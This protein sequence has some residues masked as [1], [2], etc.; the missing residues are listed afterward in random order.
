MKLALNLL[1]VLVMLVGVNG[2]RP[3]VE[4]PATTNIEVAYATGFSIE[5]LE[6]GVKKLVDGENQTILLIPAGQTAPAG[7]N[8]AVKIEIPVSR[9]VILS[10]TFGALMRPLGVLDSLVGSGTLE[11]ELY[12]EELAARYASGQ[13]QYVGAGGMG[14]PDY[15]A[16][17]ALNPDLVLLATGYPG[18]VEIYEKLKNLGINVVVC[19]DFLENDYLGRLEWIKFIAAFYQKD[20]EA[21]AHFDAVV[22]AINEIQ[23]RIAISSY[24][25]GVIWASSFMG[26][27][28]VSGNESYIA[29]GL[30]Y[31]GAVNVFNHITGAG[32]ATISLEELYVRGKDAEYFIYASTPPYINSV[33][34]IVEENPVLAEMSSVR[35]GRVYCFQPWYFQ[36]ADRPHEIILDL[37][38]IFHPNIFPDHELKHFM[39]LPAD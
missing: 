18:A 5:N 19:N 31:A 10:V 37:A 1:M 27:V 35:N 20:V 9:V 12:I 34:E 16:V 23:A 6:N 15:E 28:Y 22:E 17:R 26:T 29:R 4:D 25:P 14:D 36:I 21:A 39:L 32:S 2:C 30:R 11:N 24:L 8:S 7:Y 33:A 3:V 13:I 38:A